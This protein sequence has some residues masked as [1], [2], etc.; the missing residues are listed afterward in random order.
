[1]RLILCAAALLMA[2]PATAAE[3]DTASEVSSVVVYPDRARVTRAASLK[4]SKGSHEVLVSGLPVGLDIRSLRVE[5]AGTAK[6]VLGSLDVRRNYGSELRAGRGRELQEEILALEDAD[7][8]LADAAEAAKFES[9]FVNKLVDKATSQLGNEMLT[10]DDRADEADSLISTLGRRF[11]KSQAELRRVGIERRD[12]AAKLQ[13]ARNEARQL[14]RSSTDDFRVVVMVEAK[15]AGQLDLALS[16]TT[17]STYWRSTYDARLDPE[18]D[19]LDMTYGAW[20]WQGTGEDWSNVELSLSTAQPALGLKAPGLAPWILRHEPPPVAKRPQRSSKRSRP[21]PAPPS[22]MGSYDLDEMEEEA[23]EED[24]VAEQQVATATTEGATVEFAIPG[25]ISIPGD[26]TRKRVTIASWQVDDVAIS[27]LASPATSQ[28]VFQWAKFDHAQE[29]PLLPGELQAFLGQRYVGQSSIGRTAPGDEIE[30]PFGVEERI[31]MERELLEKGLGPKGV[32]GKKSSVAWKYEIRL[33]SLM[34]RAVVVEVR[35]A[36]PVSE[37]KKYEVKILGDTAD[38]ETD[39]RGILVFSPALS[40][41]E[42]KT[43][44][45]HYVVV[46]PTDER[47]WGL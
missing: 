8:V 30:L 3:F 27:F 45:L 31:V 25:R 11:E 39:K 26:S 19:S 20:V 47:P 1:M 2:G 34:D 43:L 40:E 35:E 29:W 17:G 23:P 33:E 9:R 12:L 7:R 28:H 4:V 22:N 42:N 24:Y 14:G 32:T 13:A 38:H 10:M 36:I 41:G 37:Y 6:V 16:Y 15:T 5:G 21:S 44:L 18:T 46:F